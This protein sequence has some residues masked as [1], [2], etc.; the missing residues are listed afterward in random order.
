LRVTDLGMSTLN[1]TGLCEDAHPYLDELCQR[2][3][4]T[5][6]LAVLDG[7]EILYV[8][9]VRSF[10]RGQNRVYLAAG[11]RLPSRWASC[12]WRTARVRAA[13][14]DRSDA[15]D[16]AR[17]EHVVSKQELR[18]EVDAI[19]EEGLTANDEVLAFDRGARA[20]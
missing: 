16:Q 3:T 11:S 4:Y 13:R 7:R 17:A 15:F 6:S 8:D 18:D 2:P 14:V 1:A 9:R 19:R 20:Q 12:C 10:R 5:S